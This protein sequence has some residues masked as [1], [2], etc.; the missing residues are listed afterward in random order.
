MAAGR[1][2]VFSENI[3]RIMQDMK[4]LRKVFID[5]FHA[6]SNQ[7]N[8]MFNCCQ[9][10]LRPKKYPI[11]RPTFCHSPAARR[12]I[13]CMLYDNKMVPKKAFTC[14]PELLLPEMFIYMLWQ[15]QLKAKKCSSH[16]QSNMKPD[17]ICS[18]YS[19]F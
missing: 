11:F 4:N 6:F 3:S 7:T 19:Q 14:C 12:R 13:V 9:C 18:A 5:F 1:L 15:C 10:C 8:L 16:F 2:I 17:N